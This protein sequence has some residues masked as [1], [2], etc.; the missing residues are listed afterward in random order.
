MSVPEGHKNKYFQN[1]LIFLETN[2]IFQILRMYKF[3]L[4]YIF[5]QS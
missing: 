2:T 3:L 5:I 1:Q 4:E